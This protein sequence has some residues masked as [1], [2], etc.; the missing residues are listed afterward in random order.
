MYQSKRISKDISGLQTSQY[1]D[2][3]VLSEYIPLKL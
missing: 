2:I 3:M 1:K